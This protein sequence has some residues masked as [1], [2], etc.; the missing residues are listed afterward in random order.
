[1]KAKEVTEKKILGKSIRAG[2]VLVIVAIATL[3]A[4]GLIQYYYSQQAI[5]QEASL[6]AQ[7]ELKGASNQIMNI[8]NQ[9]ESAVQ[10][11]MWIAKWCLDNPDSLMRVPQ[12]VVASNPVVVGSTC[13][14]GRRSRPG[15]RCS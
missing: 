12:L 15:S 8:V 11:N 6:R 14:F 13:C 9:A 3:E 1:M 4:T 10:N 2:L 5:K 7:S